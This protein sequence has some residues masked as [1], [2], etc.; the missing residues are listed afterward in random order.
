[1]GNPQKG[2]NDKENV[3]TWKRNGKKVKQRKEQNKW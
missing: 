2:I 1:M 3:E